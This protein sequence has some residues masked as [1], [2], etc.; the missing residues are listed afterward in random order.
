[1]FTQGQG[2]SVPSDFKV[3]LLDV[4]GKCSS[5]DAFDITQRFANTSFIVAF[6]LRGDG[7]DFSAAAM[8]PPGAVFALVCFFIIA[9]FCG[10]S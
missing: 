3:S 7:C 8:K 6:R 4:D 1:V 10:R 2:C 5:D 9:I